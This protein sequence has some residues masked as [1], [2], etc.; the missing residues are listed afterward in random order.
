[1]QSPKT[2]SEGANE[3][4]L[5]QPRRPGMT[6]A[7]KRSVRIAPK[8]IPSTAS[9]PTRSEHYRLRDESRLR[10]K[11]R[12]NWA[13]QDSTRQ[14]GDCKLRAEAPYLWA[15]PQLGV[16][17]QDGASPIEGS[18]P[19]PR[20]TSRGGGTLGVVSQDQGWRDRH[21]SPTDRYDPHHGDA[22]RELNFR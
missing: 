6:N 13:K 22:V 9:T 12:P 16:T 19:S 20:T 2:R 8:A 11:L 18:D 1:M 4:R 17:R 15:F 10:P 7:L 21:H 14:D 3:N 5:R